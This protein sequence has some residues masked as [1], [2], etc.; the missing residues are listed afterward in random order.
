MIQL[1]RGL[2]T[3]GLV[4][5]DPTARLFGQSTDRDWEPVT[6]RIAEEISS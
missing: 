1:I 4:V 5:H 3:T 6:A 2:L